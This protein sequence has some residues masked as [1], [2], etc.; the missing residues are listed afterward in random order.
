M[1]LFLKLFLLYIPATFVAHYGILGLLKVDFGLKEL[2]VYAI[3]LGVLTFL[4]RDVFILTGLHV[5]L[6]SICSIAML[7]YFFKLSLT[8]SVTVRAFSLM[9]L[10][11][12]EAP[13][14]KYFFPLSG[15][16]LEQV[17]AN[18]YYHILLGWLGHGLPL[19]LA[20][21]V[22]IREH[23]LTKERGKVFGQ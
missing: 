17:L 1:I 18:T 14:A 4:I 22:L 9:A 16:T 7:M 3:S 23:L 5:I 13:V 21:Y 11:I 19:I 20:G 15:L 6:L 10:T 2:A 8:K 12:G